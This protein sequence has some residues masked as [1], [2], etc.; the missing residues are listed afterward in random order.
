MM[1]SAHS[2]GDDHTTTAISKKEVP[3]KSR[4]S[5]DM[6]E[7]VE[8]YSVYT[9][10]EKW[11][12]VG[13][14][15]LGATFSPLSANIYFPAIPTL[16]DDFHKSLEL[17][18]LTVTM[19]MIFQGLAPTFWGTLADR[20]G[21]RMMFAACLILL[22]I[23]CVGLAL[24]PTSAFWLLMV[25]RCVQA[26]GSAS[27]I[28]LS[29]GVVVDI[30][31]VQE[32]GGFFGIANL[33][34]MIGPAIGPVIGGA[35][36]G[37]LGWRSIFWFLCIASGVCALVILLFLPE[38]LRA[39][40]GNG[41]HRAPRY[42]RPW[43]PLLSRG[44]EPPR[45]GAS[46]KFTNPLRLL[47]Q[48]DILVLL[49]CNA[50]INSILYAVVTSMANLFPDIYPFLDDTTL[51]LCYLT[52]G[53]GMAIG[54]V[55]VGRALDADYARYERQL[56]RKAM[57]EGR[58]GGVAQPGGFPIEKARLR[59][60]LPT[61][62]VLIVC[63][64]GLGWCYEARVHIAAPLVLL[65]IDGIMSIA[66]MNMTQTLIVDLMPKNGA[67][68]TACNNLLRCLIAAGF[69]SVLALM[70]DSMGP[71]WTFVLIDG[72]AVLFYLP[73]MFLV[74]KIGPKRRLMRAGA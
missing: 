23:S 51:G 73:G 52:I 59:L 55:L 62:V 31:D 67:S 18:N 50:L 49:L 28:A 45:A 26:A 34:P 72:I 60:V 27:T 5:T 3:P 38:T 46:A 8:P 53:G 9:R 2:S 22:C 54:T 19:Y 40:V 7:P 44:T 48:P 4:P 70:F 33:G 13:L 14:I 11:A 58:E 10:S 36:S 41:R 16:A 68:I 30:A 29:A 24:T 35:L 39:L 37:S 42:A 69:V 66:L 61:F 47:L 1:T 57:T 12:I 6:Q 15:S 56:A 64:V 43:L 74:L 71:G 25:L 20:Y 17:I 65:F 21:R 32:R 63:T